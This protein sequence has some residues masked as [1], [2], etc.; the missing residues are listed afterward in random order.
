MQL[1]WVWIEKLG[2]GLEEN[3]LISGQP[4]Q[5]A[6]TQTNSIKQTLRHHTHM[7]K[8]P[9]DFRFSTETR[10]LIGIA[11]ALLMGAPG[12]C[13]T[14]PI[15]YM[16]RLAHETRE[17]NACVLL[18][19]D[20]TFHYEKGDR[21]DTRVYEG[22]IPSAQLGEVG[23]FLQKLFSVSQKQIEEPLIHGPYDLIDIGFKENGAW[24]ELVF[25]TAESEQPYKQAVQPL[26][27][28]MDRLHKL[29]HHQ[30][31]EDAGKQNCLP[32]HRLRL[33]PREEFVE[34]PPAPTVTPNYGTAQP[35]LAPKP[36]GTSAK[37][38]P[39]LQLGMLTR[40][41]TGARQSCTL[42][43]SDGQFRFEGRSQSTGSQ[44]VKTFVARGRLGGEDLQALHAL[45]DAPALAKLHHHE[46]PGGMALNI[47]GEVIELY[48]A[49]G[50][51][52]QELVLTD[53]THRSTFFFAGDGDVSRAEPLLKF[54]H[55]Y[56][57]TKAVPGLSSERN[58]CKDLP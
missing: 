21:Y 26:L 17:G 58:G 30:F 19:K 9:D 8:G 56:F 25:R 1:R 36:A 46:P 15:S 4:G 12:F 11:M 32:R 47:M 7:P 54:L 28:W 14:K 44:T 39:L 45:L 53:S 50:A 34:E 40:N 43:A 52:V 2:V 38:T 18:Q 55:Q 10:F 20:G 23:E 49:R 29:P 42:V 24:R 6:L 51:A 5:T 16:L 48:I 33:I 22:Q 31:S 41:S 37:I 3:R 57:E 35:A 27:E 13:Q